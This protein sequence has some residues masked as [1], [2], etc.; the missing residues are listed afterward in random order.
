[1]S[2]PF[3]PY[4]EWLGLSPTT[5]RPNHYELL[6]ITIGETDAKKT[7][8]A[9]EQ[10][11]TK[12][13]SFRPGAYAAD[14]ARLLDEIQA[15]KL[16]LLDPARKVSYDQQLA[17]SAP[18]EGKNSQVFRSQPVLGASQPGIRTF[19]DL[20]PPGFRPTGALQDSLPATEVARSE[21][22]LAPELAVPA[23]PTWSAPATQIQPAATIPTAA[24]PAPVAYPVT[25]ATPVSGSFP[26][27]GLPSTYQPGYG[28]PIVQPVTT[29]VV[30]PVYSPVVP[31]AGIPT[32]LPTFGTSLPAGGYAPPFSAAAPI[33]PMAPVAI[34]GVTAVAT[35]SPMAAAPIGLA[36]AM[37]AA[38]LIGTPVADPS[39]TVAPAPTPR[40]VDASPQV[41]KASAAAAMM[42][43]RKNVQTRNAALLAGA[44]AGLV[45]V[46]G[47]AAYA[48]ISS[49]YN[50]AEDRRQVARADHSQ[51]TE[52]S[53]DKS[54]PGVKPQPSAGRDSDKA[55]S[56]PL[57][58]TDKPTVERTAQRLPSDTPPM[59][60]PASEPK[61][62]PPPTPTPTPAPKPEPAPKPTVKPTR[63][64]V[65]EL[66][67]AL[68]RA[69]VALSEQSFD[70]AEAEAAKAEKLALL[71]DHQT[72][73][74]RL[75]LA[76]DHVKLFRQALS[77]ATSKLEAAETIKVGSSTV[78][79]IVDTFPD[80][81]TVRINGMNRT[82]SFVNIPPG[83]AVAILDAK[84]IGGQ[85]DSRVLKAMFVATGKNADAEAI[86]E[87]RGWLEQVEASDS[88]AALLLKFLDD[89]YED[90]VTEFDET[91][92][93]S[94]A[95]AN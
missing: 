40:E 5:T 89:S 45:V 34:P 92:K 86:G 10:T 50:Q 81:I 3:N 33:D 67:T 15:A 37:P 63:Q 36:A 46:A 88:H 22:V 41:R 54:N 29:P 48:V 8:L 23:T 31:S 56:V 38:M 20:Y 51:G 26:P 77:E 32:A 72:L 65:A 69:K 16:T 24:M 14:W 39:G 13:R 93:R 6:G 90:L 55:S 71:P 53:R 59:N 19:S 70:E 64:Q 25:V 1:M 66:E 43:A 78:V 83:L 11:A 4:R 87:A 52:G 21:S 95:A 57:S 28:V 2:E 47:L 82:Y 85:P 61:P 68:K 94:T 7:A 73:V 74:E 58:N 49:R 62:E 79:A 42:T 75:R 76:I 17:G 80:K 60:V 27:M 44:A 91:E 35:P 30:T 84:R 12:V 9:A 18:S